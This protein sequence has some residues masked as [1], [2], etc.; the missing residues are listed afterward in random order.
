MPIANA[1]SA[2]GVAA[3]RGEIL[4]F[5]GDPAMLGDAAHRHFADGVLV[6]RDGRVAA[7]GQ[8]AAVL[9]DAAVRRERSSTTGAS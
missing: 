2:A 8:A 7:L 3:F 5:V 1:T 6:V 4:D 9:P